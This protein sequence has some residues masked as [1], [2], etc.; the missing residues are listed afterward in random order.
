MESTALLNAAMIISAILVEI[1]VDR[2]NNHDLYDTKESA[3]NIF[4]FSVSALLNVFMKGFFIG[5]FYFLRRYNMFEIGATWYWWMICLLLCDFNF[6]WFHF[7]GHRVRFLWAIHVV[8]HSGEKM[9]LTS[10]LRL[11]VFNSFFRLLIHTP[12]VLAGF[13][14]VMV[15]LCDTII[16]SYSFL[17]HTETII[18]LGVL[19]KIFNTPSHHRVHHASNPQYIDKNYGGMFIIWD[20]L[21][22]TFTKENQKCIYGLTSPLR[23]YN[24]IKIIF[25]EWGT[26][27]REIRKANNLRIAMKIFFSPPSAKKGIHKTAEIPQPTP[28]ENIYLHK[29]A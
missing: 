21:F 5:L 1:I 4:L 25:H 17:L 26:M 19:E 12:L 28:A 9:N 29:A 8:H 15:L 14:P 6:F 11:P 16:Y 24:P 7:L 27:I 3:V 22:G 10:A 20:K 2:F 18:S 23:S 13:S